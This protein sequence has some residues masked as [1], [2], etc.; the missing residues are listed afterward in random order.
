MSIPIPL[1][2]DEDFAA[3][4]VELMP[5]V[6]RVEEDAANVPEPELMSMTAQLVLRE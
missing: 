5:L 1:L 3:D 4:V 6:A 2:V